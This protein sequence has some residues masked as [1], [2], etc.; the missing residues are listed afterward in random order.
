MIPRFFH[1]VS[2]NRISFFLWKKSILLCIHSTLFYPFISWWTQDFYCFLTDISSTYWYH[3]FGCSPSS[4][5]VGLYSSSIFNFFRASILF[6]PLAVLIYNSSNSVRVFPQPCQLS[7]LI[8]YILS[9]IKSYC[10]VH[11]ICI[12]WWLVIWNTFSCM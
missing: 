7:L 3:F 10:I 4:G 2:T 1:V 8:L 6:F 11:L 5:I 12:I 9:S